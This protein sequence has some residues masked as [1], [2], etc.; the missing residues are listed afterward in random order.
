MAVP[1][2]WKTALALSAGATPD[3]ANNPRLVSGS[4]QPAET[5]SKSGCH[6]TMP[7]AGCNGSVQILGLPGCYV[8]GQTY[9]LDVKVTDAQASRWGF[10]VGVQ[11]N[12]GNQFNYVTAGTLANA[13][14]ARTQIVTSADGQ[15]SF[16]THNS[17][18]ANGDGTF[19]GQTGSATYTFTWTAPGGAQLQ[20]AICFYVA[21][22]AANNN[23]ARSG[24]CTYTAKVCLQP[25]G[26]VHTQSSTWGEVKSYY[27]R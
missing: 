4:V 3:K 22:L 18:S 15:R 10:E 6:D 26:P 16:V 24:D 23:D 14:G 9:T 12:E 20:T 19:A 5:C 25:C 2:L 21:G 8:A 27:S 13:A 11:Y 7:A 1:I 17:A